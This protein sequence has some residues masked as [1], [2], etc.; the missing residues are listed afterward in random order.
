[1]EVNGGDFV[2]LFEDLLGE[3]F[4]TEFVDDVVGI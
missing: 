3:T 1:L 2:E 4:F